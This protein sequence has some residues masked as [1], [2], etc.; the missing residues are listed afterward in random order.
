MVHLNE[1]VERHLNVFLYSIFIVLRNAFEDSSVFRST[2]L[3][4]QRGIVVYEE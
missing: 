1:V 4:K 2:M 3:I